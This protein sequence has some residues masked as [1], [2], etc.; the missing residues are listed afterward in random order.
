MNIVISKKPNAS[1]LNESMCSLLIFISVL[2]S[3]VGCKEEQV[4]K[5]APLVPALQVTSASALTQTPFAGRA[6][7]G[8]EVNLSFRVSGNLNALPVKVGDEIKKGTLVAQLEP[9]DFIN[10]VDTAKGQLNRAKAAALRAQSDYQRLLNVYREDPGAT[11]KAAL[12]LAK[13]TRDSSKATVNSIS[14]TVT[15]AQNQLKYTKLLA[16]F[17]GV[18]VSSYVENF[19]T[20]VAKQPIVRLVD[21][22]TLEFVIAVPETSINYFSFVQ[23]VEVTFDALPDIA[24]PAVIQEVGREASQATQTYPVTLEL[25]QPEGV[26]VLPGMAGSAMVTTKAPEAEALK[27]GIE[28]PA[29]AVFKKSENSYVWVIDTA[30]KTVTSRAVEVG[31]LSPSGV[32]IESGIEPGEWIAIKGVHS[33]REGQAIRIADFAAGKEGK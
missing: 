22:S 14:S 17:S 12:D 30:S 5:P 19:E 26:E 29:T 28:I 23:S 24:I 3:L 27:R 1:M 8:Q 31:E 25:Q 32:F 15:T 20:V 6:S 7:A 13:A 4:E 21:I 18:I 10:A 2:L 9:Q 11:S 33:M 16:P